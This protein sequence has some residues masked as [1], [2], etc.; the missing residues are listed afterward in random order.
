MM[1]DINFFKKLNDTY[2]HDVGDN[3]LKLVA[4]IL[5]NNTRSH[6]VVARFGGEEFVILL[7]ETAL[8]G[9]V[10]V[11]ERIRMAIESFNFKPLG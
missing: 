5:T 6:D 1:L 4:N 7:P 10:V 8:S 3:V 11:A 2:G 9:A